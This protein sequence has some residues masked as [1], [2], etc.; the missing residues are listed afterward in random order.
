MAAAGAQSNAPRPI[1]DL[2]RGQGDYKPGPWVA[3]M[4]T[5]VQLHISSLT[6]VWFWCDEGKVSVKVKSQVK[7]ELAQIRETHPQIRVKLCVADTLGLDIVCSL[8]P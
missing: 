5:M 8:M 1:F 2:M 4:L 6:T 3:Q 7:K